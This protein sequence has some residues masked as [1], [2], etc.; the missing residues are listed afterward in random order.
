MHLWFIIFVLLLA[1]THAWWGASRFVGDGQSRLAVMEMVGNGVWRRSLP[2]CG[3][4]QVI[5]WCWPPTVHMGLVTKAPKDPKGCLQN[6]RGLWWSYI[7]WELV[8]VNCEH[9]LADGVSRLNLEVLCSNRM[10]WGI[11]WGVLSV[12]A[13]GSIKHLARIIFLNPPGWPLR[14]SQSHKCHSVKRFSSSFDSGLCH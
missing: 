7:D 9:A 14:I 1:C 5:P 11:L 13:W 4:W 8:V 10:V 2:C 12:N 6:R 3:R